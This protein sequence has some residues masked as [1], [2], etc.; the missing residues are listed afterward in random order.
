MADN[1]LEKKFEAMRNPK[2]KEEKARERAWKKR[3]KA[4]KEKLDNE[5]NNNCDAA[6]CSEQ[7]SVS[8]E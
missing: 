8:S 4:Y 5:K 6:A 3:M 7:R 2:T 1:W